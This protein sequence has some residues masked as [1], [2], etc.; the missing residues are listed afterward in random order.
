MHARSASGLGRAIQAARH[1][2]GM[3]QSDLAD[4]ARTNRF[5]IAALESGRSTK[6]I[7]TLF[8]TLSA[9]DLEMVVRPRQS[10]KL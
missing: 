7:E 3:T 5:A 6:A 4:R 1:A 2:K 8:E 9:L 10:W